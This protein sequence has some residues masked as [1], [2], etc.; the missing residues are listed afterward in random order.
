MDFEEINDTTRIYSDDNDKKYEFRIDEDE[1]AVYITYLGTSEVIGEFEFIEVGE[2]G[3]KTTFEGYKLRYMDVKDGYKRNGLGT[4]A[5]EFF[6]EFYGEPIIVS[7]YNGMERADGSHLTG[8]GLPFAMRL[9][10]LGIID[11]EN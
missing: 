5:V 11:Y 10:E 2:Y 3:Y 8:E 1:I 6:K 7:S 9:L 4:A